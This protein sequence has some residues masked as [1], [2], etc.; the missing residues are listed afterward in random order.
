[1]KIKHIKDVGVLKKLGLLILGVILP[2]FLYIFIF[3]LPNV[4]EHL[5]EEKRIATRHI[6]EV[7]KGI[8]EGFT[9]QEQKGLLSKE[10]AQ[11]KAISAINTLRYN[12]DDYF[13]I[14]NLDLKMVMHPINSALNGKDISENKDPNGVYIFREANNIAK[15]AGGGFVEYM[16]P[17]PGYSQP[18][19]KISYV[20]LIKEW[21]WVVGSGIYVD[22]VA[23]QISEFYISAIIG[24]VISLLIALG[25]S[26]Y[27]STFITRP[28]KS[29]QQAASQ[30][31]IGDANYNVEITSE[32]E[33]G[34]LQ[35]AFKE[36]LSSL[37]E[38]ADVAD[39]ISVGDMKADINVRSDKDVLSKS[40]LKLKNTLH[41]LVEELK[42]LTHSAKEGKLSDRGHA[43]KFNGGFK[44]IIVGVNETLDAVIKP[45]NEGSKVLEKMALGDFTV[46]VTGEFKG[47]H[48]II[49]NSINSLGESLSQILKEVN[50]AVEATASAS[51]EISSSTEEMA[52]GSQELSSQTSEVASA[53]EQMTRTIMETTKNTAA[54]A[55]SAK[56]A[57]QKAKEGG[58]VV[59]ETISG[60]VKITQVVNKS[61]DTVE[62]LGKSSNQIGE[63]IL[64]ID[65]IADQ[66]NLLALNAAIEA[67]RAGEQGRGFA[68]VADEVRKLAE[69]TTKATKEIAD[70]IKQIQRDTKEAVGAMQVGKDE[71][72]KGKALAEKAGASLTQIIEKAN[73]VM[74][75]ITQVAAASEEQS[76]AA[77]Q[78]S[79]S[80]E[81]IDS[82]TRESASGIQQVARAS[83]DL[84]RLTLELQNLTTR[85]KVDDSAIT[86]SNKLA[87]NR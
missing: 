74:D 13:W 84:N 32:D 16:W 66:T 31:A 46:K 36:M 72:E 85:F 48:Q 53:V 21:G 2:L 67:A 81:G 20:T 78:I 71:V 9:L 12:Q 63:I 55:E 43:E 10:E 86:K 60:I 73:S 3:L 35:K 83:E 64:V 24:I 1:M 79:K 25:I 22:D 7:A 27:L 52:A 37:K 76:S 34:Q 30:V 38:K 19:P 41:N 39:R 4:E 5:L 33:F 6:V 44:D 29:L 69:R 11:T 45:V 82:V 47:D 17:K 70:M 56:E 28:L 23:E 65:E 51:S 68:V 15:A 80:I 50:Q 8:V 59:E 61:A 40:I 87:Y 54:A 77:E 75:I 18:Q 26:Y 42:Q 58:K 14:N 49:K 62:I 57:G